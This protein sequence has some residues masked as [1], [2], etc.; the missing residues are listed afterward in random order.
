MPYGWR[1]KKICH[2]AVSGIKGICIKIFF[3]NGNIEK[4]DKFPLMIRSLSSTSHSKYNLQ[5]QFRHLIF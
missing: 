1:V 5:S 4:T 3:I 2:Q